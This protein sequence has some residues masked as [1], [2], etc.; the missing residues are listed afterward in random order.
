MHRHLIKNLP[1]ENEIISNW[2][3]KDVLLSITC[4]A[5]NHANFIAESING[6]LIQK[7]T[8]PFEIIIHDDASSDDS[9]SI[10][11]KYFMKNFLF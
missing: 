8:F 10:I 11:L 5:Y 3:S 7:T 2:E 4:I 1:S 9:Q 6:F